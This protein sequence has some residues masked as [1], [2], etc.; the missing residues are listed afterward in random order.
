M[1]KIE[2]EEEIDTMKKIIA[3]LRDSIPGESTWL[4]QRESTRTL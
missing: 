3:T 1:S 4:K 2:K